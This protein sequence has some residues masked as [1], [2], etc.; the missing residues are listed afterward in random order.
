MVC[1]G[2]ITSL[3]GTWWFVLVMSRVDLVVWEGRGLC[4]HPRSLRSL[5]FPNKLVIVVLDRHFL[6]HS[7][8]FV[9]SYD[10]VK[11]LILCLEF[12]WNRAV[13]V[14]YCSVTV[15]VNFI[16][17]V[18][19]GCR[20]VS[21]FPFHFVIC[22]ELSVWLSKS[23]LLSLTTIWVFPHLLHPTSRCK[24]LTMLFYLSQQ[25]GHHRPRSLP[26]PS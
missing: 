6:V 20:R 16:T 15:V 21:E 7:L 19:C 11:I 13:K 25:S 18:L 8:Q 17:E 14:V 12:D 10:W 26:K 5:L 4:D 22:S 9:S 1:R 3:V 23:S 24:A 2:M